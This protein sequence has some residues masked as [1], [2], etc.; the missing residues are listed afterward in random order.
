MCFCLVWQ[1]YRC[2]YALQEQVE[3]ADVFEEK[4][5]NVKGKSYMGDLVPY[6]KHSK[7][8]VDT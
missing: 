5:R 8:T 3:K 4:L 7:Y 1:Q 6:P 2:L